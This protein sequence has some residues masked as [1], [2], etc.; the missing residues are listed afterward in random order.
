MEASGIEARGDS[1]MLMEASGMEASGIEASGDASTI[2]PEPVIF[3]MGTSKRGTSITPGS[4]LLVST[5]WDTSVKVGREAATSTA[6]MSQAA[7][8]GRIAPRWSRGSHVD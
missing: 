5:V 7:P 1:A 4:V 6:P 3:S 2:S 8:S